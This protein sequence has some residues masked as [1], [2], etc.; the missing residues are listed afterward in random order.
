MWISYCSL[1]KT[2]KIH[3]IFKKINRNIYNIF[4]EIYNEDIFFILHEH[5]SKRAISLTDV[6]LHEKNVS[7][8]NVFIRILFI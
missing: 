4:L 7:K 8:T 2:I 6:F 5:F 3:R 1:L